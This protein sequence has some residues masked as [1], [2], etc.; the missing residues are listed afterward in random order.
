MPR[1]C[2][3]AYLAALKAQV[4]Y[5]AI[6][7]S[8]TMASETVYLWS[9]YG[10]VTWNNQTWTGT[11]SLL[12]IST[13]E[14]GADVN[15]RGITISLSGIDVNLLQTVLNEF[16]V[17][18]PVTVYLGLFD[19]NG[20]LIPNPVVSFAGRM[21]EPTITAD[22]TTATIAVNCESRLMDMN[23]SVP[24]R[25]TNQDQQMFYPGDL[26]FSFV[27]SIQDIPLYWGQTAN[28]DG[29]P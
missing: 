20:N 22:A 24:Y 11:G 27:T 4:M 10:P 13:V 1:N 15:A 12:G 5:P 9:G 6:F 29:N 23:V 21:D 18:L 7:V 3:P 26:G 2:T 14:E 28:S 8:A 16:Q 17:G 25:Y 19:G